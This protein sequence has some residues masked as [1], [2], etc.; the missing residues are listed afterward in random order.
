MSELHRLT[1]AE[2]DFLCAACDMGSPI[3]YRCLADA[4][5]IFP[6]AAAR[7]AQALAGQGYVRIE[8]YGAFSL[9]EAG[10]ALAAYHTRRR[11]VVFAFAC[12]LMGGTT[13]RAVCDRFCESLSDAAIDAMAARLTEGSAMSA[14]CPRID[15]RKS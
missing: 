4:L 11:S 9:T 10:A 5:S 2:V 13:D 3:P 1:R 12:W 15:F 7:L 6:A 8:G 14:T